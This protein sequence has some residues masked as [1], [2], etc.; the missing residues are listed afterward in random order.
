MKLTPEKIAA[1]AK[2]KA[3]RRSGEIHATVEILDATFRDLIADL[4][5]TQKELENEKA[6]GIHSCHDNCTQDGCVNRRLRDEL[7]AARQQLEEAQ[8]QLDEA[9]EHC[10]VAAWNHFMDTCKQ[11]NINPSEVGE[12]CSAAAIRALNKPPLP[13]E[14]AKERERNETHA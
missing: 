13:E 11:K 4:E 9:Y 12:Y 7:S 8:E 10:A 3:Y 1:L 6:R 5:E 14:M 2:L